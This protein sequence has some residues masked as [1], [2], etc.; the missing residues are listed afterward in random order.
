MRSLKL[1]A[2]AA[3]TAAP[4]AAPLTAA[5]GMP[6]NDDFDARILAA[7]A[8]FEGTIESIRFVDSQAGGALE[9]G[10]PHTFVTY[11]VERVFKGRVRGDRVT[12]RFFGGMDAA[13]DRLLF[14][15]DG[16]QPDVGDR[17]ILLVAGNGA[18]ECPIVGCANGRF[19]LIGESVYD[20][21]GRDLVQI[22]RQ[23]VRRGTV[24]DLP[25]I[26][27]WE[28]TGLGVG[29]DERPDAP[30]P[31][32]TMSAEGFRGFIADRVAL[33]HPAGELFPIVVSADPAAP[34]AYRPDD[35]A[36]PPEEPAPAPSPLRLR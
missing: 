16:V 18:A 29:F 30:D 35:I 24:R 26:F 25:E 3:L 33:L 22:D 12:L 20:E 5:A 10:V 21:G 2:L 8:V 36:P 27:T 17:D 9:R 7:D 34:F 31:R 6:E 4:L 11:R 32:A 23:T 1:C 19:R 28:E 13:R 15:S 14:T